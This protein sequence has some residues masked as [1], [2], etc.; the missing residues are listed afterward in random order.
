MENSF[1]F[2]T[3]QKADRVSYSFLFYNFYAQTL[4]ASI[5]ANILKGEL[6]TVK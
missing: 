6:R 5:L 1:V 4:Q 2:L 3:N